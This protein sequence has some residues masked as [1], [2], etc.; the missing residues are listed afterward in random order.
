MKILKSLFIFLFFIP[1]V[2][3]AQEPSAFGGGDNSNIHIQGLSKTERD[4]VLNRDNIENL[5]NKLIKI[6][7]ELDNLSGSF[8]GLRSVFEGELSR[9]GTINSDIS[10]ILETQESYKSSID[11]LYIDQNRTKNE[12]VSTLNSNVDII[13][14]NIESLKNSIKD[15]G[16]LVSKINRE[17]V[18]KDEFDKYVNEIKKIFKDYEE[19]RSE[20]LNTFEGK[21]NFEIY[22]DAKKYFENSELTKA[23]ERF[24]HTA[25]NNY[26]P[27]A[28]N[29]YLGEIAFKN[30]N[31]NDSIYY[32]K[33]SASLYDKADYMSILLLNSAISLKNLENKD[34]SKKFLE[35][36]ISLYPDSNESKRAKNI[37]NEL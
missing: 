4:V 34:E 12:L 15:L 11:R 9:F 3:F 37:L 13:S 20:A 2:L 5:N 22:S 35:T 1:I 27:A 25:S 19:I 8:E 17:Y 24:E 21:E 36:L 10:K 14:K 31:F 32:Y 16:A 33:K 7:R 18:S 6:D 30:N 28:S 26:Y 23:K 29:Y